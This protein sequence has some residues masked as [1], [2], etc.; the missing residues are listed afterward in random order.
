MNELHSFIVF[1]E[2]LLK[3]RVF[4]SYKAFNMVVKN[5]LIRSTRSFLGIF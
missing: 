4:L 3:S 1:K 5:V 2:S